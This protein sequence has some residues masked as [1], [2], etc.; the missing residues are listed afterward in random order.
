MQNPDGTFNPFKPGGKILWYTFVGCLAALMIA[1]TVSGIMHLV[2][3][4]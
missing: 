1:L 2:E 3:W 4:V